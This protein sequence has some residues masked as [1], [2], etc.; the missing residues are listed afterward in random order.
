[1]VFGGAGGRARGCVRSRSWKRSRSGAVRWGPRR[2]RRGG[3]GSTDRGRPG[4]T[5]ARS[6]GGSPTRRL[7]ARE[8]GLAQAA[9]ARAVEHGGL[10]FASAPWLA[11]LTAS[12]RAP[13]PSNIGRP[14]V[15]A[16]P[17]DALRG[18][19]DAVGEKRYLPRLTERAILGEPQT[20]AQ[21]FLDRLDEIHRD[22]AG[23]LRSGRPG[24][25]RGVRH[26]HLRACRRGLDERPAIRRFLAEARPRLRHRGA[27]V[28]AFATSGG[29]S[30]TDPVGRVHRGG[31]DRRSGGPA[32]PR[33]PD[34]VGGH[35]RGL[36]A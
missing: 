8:R 1:M 21:R 28:G 36:P 3:R 34:A 32:R 12:T 19:A 7:T 9:I 5:A 22:E 14:V 4:R 23:A 31:A 35:R 26:R 24:G 10:G 18:A 17:E 13:L 11:D 15:V 25:T 2:G 6:V 30:P 27:I 16:S 33:G 20:V 29:T